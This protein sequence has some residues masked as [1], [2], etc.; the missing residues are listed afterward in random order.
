MG[1]SQAR[2][3]G[4]GLPP[5]GRAETAAYLD[6]PAVRRGAGP[7]HA[8]PA[9]LPSHRQVLGTLGQ[10]VVMSAPQPLHPPAPPHPKG[11]AA[12]SAAPHAAVCSRHGPEGRGDAC[13]GPALRPGCLVLP[14][15]H[16]CF[17]PLP[18]ACLPGTFQPRLPLA[19]HLPAL[20]PPSGGSGQCWAGDRPGS[21]PLTKP[22]AVGLGS[23]GSVHRGRLT[24]GQVSLQGS[25]SHCTVGSWESVDRQVHVWQGV[26]AG[27]VAP[28]WGGK[29]DDWGHWGRPGPCLR[30]GGS[31]TRPTGWLF[32]RV[33][34]C[35]PPA[36]PRAGQ[37]G[38]GRHPGSRGRWEGR[39]CPRTF[40]FPWEEAAG[41]P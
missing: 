4:G 34:G 13:P 39:C 33:C 5:G 30:P 1:F 18:S 26:V 2:E 15:P 32:R 41:R 20:Q 24:R 23:P 29:G 35:A 3:P 17:W 9:A 40:P 11:P 31:E 38:V 16:P 19:H 10:R 25:S 21:G 8:L 22:Q 36:G 14:Q 37:A 28:T 12:P 7:L 27:K 6:Q